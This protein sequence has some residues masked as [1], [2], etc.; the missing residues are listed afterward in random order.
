[1]HAFRNMVVKEKLKCCSIRD[2][3]VRVKKKK[4]RDGMNLT[5]LMPK[6]DST[7]EKIVPITDA[8]GKNKKVYENIWKYDYT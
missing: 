6:N 3:V 1:M 4:F 8:Y 5:R 7:L 2:G